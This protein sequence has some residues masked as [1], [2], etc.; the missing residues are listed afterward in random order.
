MRR[1]REAFS[2]FLPPQNFSLQ[3]TTTSVWYAGYN[4]MK[5]SHNLKI[6]TVGHREK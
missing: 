6:N 1:G 4:L 3:S 5:K 2:P